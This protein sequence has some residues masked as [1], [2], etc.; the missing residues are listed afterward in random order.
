[1]LMQ[2]REMGRCLCLFFFVSIM[3]V[4]VCAGE[5]DVMRKSISAAQQ[6]KTNAPAIYGNTGWTDEGLNTLISDPDYRDPVSGELGLHRFLMSNPCQQRRG[7]TEQTSCADLRVL[8]LFVD[9]SDRR[10]EDAEEKFQ[11]FQT[12]LDFLAPAAQWLQQSS[13]GQLQLRFIAPQRDRQLNW[14]RLS[15]AATDYVVN[16]EDHLRFAYVREIAQVAYDR[17]QIRVDD[18]DTVLIMPVKGDAGLPNGPATISAHDVGESRFPA[19]VAYIDQQGN[20]HGIDHFITAGNDM[21]R[22]GALW[23]VH[24]LGHLFGLPDTYLYETKIRGQEVNRFFY[25]GGWDMMGNIGGHSSDFFSWHKLKLRWLSDQQVIK[26]AN[27]VRHSIHQLTP[28]ETPGGVKLLVIPTGLRTAYVAELRSGAG[29]N[30]WPTI[31]RTELSNTARRGVLIYRIDAGTWLSTDTPVAQVISRAYYHSAMVGEGEN[32]TGFWRALDNSADPQLG[33]ALWL[34][35]DVFDDPKTGVRIRIDQLMLN[36]KNPARI[37]VTVTKKLLVAVKP[38]LSIVSACTRNE[39]E[40][41]ITLNRSPRSLVTVVGDGTEGPKSLQ[42]EIPLT[43]LV[44]RDFALR[45]GARWLNSEQE[46]VSVSLEDKRL[47]L[48]LKPGVLG[49]AA[50]RLSIRETMHFSAAAPV[51]LK[52]CR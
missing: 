46:I 35:G 41:D 39:T 14:I 47:R 52:A 19:E 27:P 15:H 24:E 20:A 4:T 25:V 36:E 44:A 43:R 38:V 17:Y 29:V 40:L 42:Q 48:Q 13:Y 50:L 12:Y 30:A 32:K 31:H 45:R 49:G 9:F 26:V 18:Y 23:F 51:V 5:S 8:V 33:G 10:V 6:K 3:S 21:F 1:M 34:E 2:C 28:V 16:R 7:N 11:A 37:A 22:W